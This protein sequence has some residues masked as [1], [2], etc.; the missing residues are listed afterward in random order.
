M[1]LYFL[2]FNRDAAW[3]LEPNAFNDLL[4][5]YLHCDAKLCKCPKGDNPRTYNKDDTLVITIEY[6]HTNC[7]LGQLPV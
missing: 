7:L 2:N 4:E 5:R 6:S 1:A 3:E